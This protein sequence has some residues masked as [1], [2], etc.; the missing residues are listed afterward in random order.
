M[1][2]NLDRPLQAV[3]TAEVDNQKL[4]GEIYGLIDEQKTSGDEHPQHDP[5]I[6]TGRK[7]EGEEEEDDDINREAGD[8]DY[9]SAELNEMALVASMQ[10]IED[11][12]NRKAAS[13]CRLATVNRSRSCD[14]PHM[15]SPD[16]RGYT[17][18][19]PGVMTATAS[20]FG[21]EPFEDLYLGYKDGFTSATLQQTAVGSARQRV[22][23]RGA[24]PCSRLVEFPERPRVRSAGRAPERPKSQARDKAVKHAIEMMTTRVRVPPS[25][26]SMHGGFGVR[27]PRKGVYDPCIDAHARKET[28]P[29]TYLDK[30]MFF[31]YSLL[32]SCLALKCCYSLSHISFCGIPGAVFIKL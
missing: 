7:D 26:P 1:I 23:S 16:F 3:T 18:V 32:W 19:P 20:E 9:Q 2:T 24:T 28:V 25:I 4:I 10:A 17:P 5:V 31:R 22:Q 29:K 14:H 8:G 21:V 11:Y 30:G 27:S 6:P 12:R 15:T 13:Q